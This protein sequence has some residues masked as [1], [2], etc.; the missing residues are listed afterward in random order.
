[1]LAAS[2]TRIGELFLVFFGLFDG[3]T[4]FSFN[5]S[6]RAGIATARGFDDFVE[7]ILR[8]GREREGGGG[9]SRDFFA[10]NNHGNDEMAVVH[11]DEVGLV[12]DGLE[13][14][15]EDRGVVGGNAEGDGGTDVAEDGIADGVGHLGDILVGDGEVEAVF[16]GFGKN[17]GEGI[18]GE[19]LE[20]VD[21]EIEG[22]AVGDVGNV[23]AGHSSELD[24]GDEEGAKDAGVVFTNEPL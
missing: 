10:V 19:V 21:I 9:E 3:G 5:F 6:A 14:F 24:F 8:C 4:N 2:A 1:M 20:L 12:E 23:G 11:L 15:G 7:I 18:G 16:A 17:D 22:A 13:L